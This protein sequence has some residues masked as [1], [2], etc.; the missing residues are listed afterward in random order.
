M[1]RATG[2][3]MIF[4]AIITGIYFGWRST[5][6]TDR[7]QRIEQL[8]RR[9]QANIDDSDKALAEMRALIQAQSEC[10]HAR[11]MEGD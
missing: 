10:E 3:V 7:L 4:A 9:V 1:T 11:C 6:H 2:V 8:D 5:E